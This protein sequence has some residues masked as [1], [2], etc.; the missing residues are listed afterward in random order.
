VAGKKEGR[1]KRMKEIFFS[2][3]EKFGLPVA[4]MLGMAWGI[5]QGT[6]WVGENVVKPILTTH[7][8]LV[9]DVGNESKEQTK[10]LVKIQANQE[11]QMK[12]L[13]LL[14]KTLEKK[15]R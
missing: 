4:L 2:I 12:T 8:E 1:T 3:A 6:I 13:E 15:W 7:L 10:V 5:S 9:K 11:Q 14:N